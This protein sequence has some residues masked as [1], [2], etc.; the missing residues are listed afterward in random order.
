MNSIFSKGARVLVTGAN[1][2]FGRSTLKVL[3]ELDVEVF[4]TSN[5]QTAINFGNRQ[6]EVSNWD[7]ARIVAF[8]PNVVVD[9]A[10]LTKERFGEFTPEEY[11]STNRMLVQRA[12]WL[13]GLPSVGHFVGFSSGA[14]ITDPSHPYG[15]I[16]REYEVALERLQKSR[17]ISIVVARA[18]SV[19]GHLITK[20]SM[21]AL[22]DFIM[23]ARSGTIKIN[24]S[25][26]VQRRY[27]SIEDLLLLSSRL[28]HERGFHVVDSGG[29]LVELQELAEIVAEVVNPAARITRQLNPNTPA[30]D[31]FSDNI[32]WQKACEITNFQPR[33]L[34]EQIKLVADQLII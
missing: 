20:P 27:V 16:K 4:A 1:G 14:S 24:A 13:A 31:Y 22:S 2:W 23:Q 10:F 21:F 5:R 6:F 8:Q 25:G 7:E 32:S 11:I 34:R 28:A 19:S 17:M 29:Q 33:N 15:M 12:L 3:G 30:N 26:A 9:C 18:W